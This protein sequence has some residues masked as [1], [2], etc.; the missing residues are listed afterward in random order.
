[1]SERLA[2]ASQQRIPDCLGRLGNAFER[3]CL[4]V[5]GL[6]LLPVYVLLQQLLGQLLFKN[7]PAELDWRDLGG[8]RRQIQG[9]EAR[10]HG[11]GGLVGLVRTVPINDQVGLLP[12][13]QI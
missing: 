10:A 9:M 11:G 2:G 1:M 4:E 8:C 6:Q 12:L 7:L 13:R 5:S 3:E